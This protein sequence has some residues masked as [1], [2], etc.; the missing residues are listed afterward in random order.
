MRAGQAMDLL[1]FS[2]ISALAEKSSA[3]THVCE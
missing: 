3:Y 2:E 1:N